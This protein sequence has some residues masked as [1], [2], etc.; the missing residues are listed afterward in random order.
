MDAALRV[1]ARGGSVVGKGAAMAALRTSSAIM[2]LVLLALPGVA[3]CSRAEPVAQEQTSVRSATSGSGA[4]DAG[5]GASSG[6]PEKTELTIG[7]CR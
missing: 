2:A 4:D 6:A 7:R 1:W 3:G 5:D